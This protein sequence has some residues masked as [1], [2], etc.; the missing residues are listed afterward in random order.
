MSDS[1]RKFEGDIQ[2][3][4]SYPRNEKIIKK[5]PPKVKVEA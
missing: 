4:I 2:E 3:A 5:S 1:F